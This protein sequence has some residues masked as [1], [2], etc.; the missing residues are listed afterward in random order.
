MALVCI[1]RPSVGEALEIYHAGLHDPS[2]Q[3]LAL[4]VLTLKQALQ[5]AASLELP[6]LC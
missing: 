1:V 3:K 6:S 5:S 2:R 4:M